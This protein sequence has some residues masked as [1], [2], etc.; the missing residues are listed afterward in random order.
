MSDSEREYSVSTGE[1]LARIRRL[2]DI[3]EIRAL[4]YHYAALLDD[5]AKRPGDAAVA[6]HI[7][8]LFTEDFTADYGRFGVYRGRTELMNFL[9]EHIPSVSAWTMHFMA[10]PRIDVRGDR[11]TGEWYLTAFFVSRSDPAASPTPLYG[12]YRD[13]LVRTADGWR[14]RSLTMI[15]DALPAP[16]DARTS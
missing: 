14:I 11:A 8:S 13:E 6:V 3:E 16:P 12:H 9:T 4:K 1:L 5:A 2:E 7:T 15:F 10:N